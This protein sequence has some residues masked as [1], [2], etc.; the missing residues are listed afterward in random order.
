MSGGTS[1]YAHLVRM[2]GLFV[3]GILLFLGGRS[4]FVPKDFGVY[5]HYRAGALDDARARPIK[6]AGQA[7]CVECHANIGD[8]RKTTRHAKVSCESCHGPLASHAA[9]DEPA[10]PTRPDGLKT[11][12]GCHTKS[13][14]KPPTFPQVVVVDH[15][16][17]NACIVCHNPHA[18]KMS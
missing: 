10:K 11:C 4:F 12:V 14:S 15:A 9:G 5:G 2:A 3:L 7:T 1:N 18:P 8:L 6:F 13:P 16:A 17:D